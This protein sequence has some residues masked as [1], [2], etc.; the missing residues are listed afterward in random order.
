MEVDRKNWKWCCVNQDGLELMSYGQLI[1]ENMKELQN[2]FRD[3][4]KRNRSRGKL[5][6][7]GM[8][9]PRRNMIEMKNTQRKQA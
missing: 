8:V 6:E 1:S 5:S 2:G 7:I 3:R 4:W 9:Y